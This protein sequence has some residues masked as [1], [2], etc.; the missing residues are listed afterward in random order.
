MK[1]KEEREQD[2]R[3]T[4]A[5]E[6]D[7]RAPVPLGV[8]RPEDTE[9]PLGRLPEDL[10]EDNSRL[11]AGTDPLSTPRSPR[12]AALATSDHLVQLAP[13]EMRVQ[14]EVTEDPERTAPMEKTPCCTQLRRPS[15]VLC[16]RPDPP[17]LKDPLDPRDHLDQRDPLESPHAMEFQ[18][19]KECK[20]NPA[21]SDAQEE[22]VLEEA[23]DSPEDSFPFPDL[24]D[25]LDPP[26]RPESKVLKVSQVPTGSHSRDLL[27]S[28]ET[29]VVPEEKVVPDQPV[30]RGPLEKTD[31][32]ELATTV[33]S[34]EPRLAINGRLGA[35]DAFP[36]PFEV[37]S[38]VS[39]ILSL[40]LASFLFSTQLK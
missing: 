19:N 32:R 35:A 24:R 23:Q 38:A 17:D 37:P 13:R 31:R 39:A 6:P 16:A 28:Q 40:L 2:H 27:D 10:R 7:H 25:H 5:E 18:E 34:R 22:K 29:P 15:L 11:A 8:P 12:S 9:G 33:P 20:D 21:R 4:Q 3:V 36:R 14:M 30:P 1:A 26:A